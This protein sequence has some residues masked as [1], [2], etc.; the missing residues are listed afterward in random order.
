MSDLRQ[1][2]QTK[3]YHIKYS[4]CGKTTINPALYKLK[5]RTSFLFQ[6]R[7]HKQWLKLAVNSR[8][9]TLVP[10]SDVSRETSRQFQEPHHQ[11]YSPDIIDVSVNWELLIKTALN[12][13]LKVSQVKILL[14]KIPISHRDIARSW[15]LSAVEIRSRFSS[16]YVCEAVIKSFLDRFP[17]YFNF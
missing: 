8:H 11:S 14:S 3:K 12:I 5:L 9:S 4:N 16:F 13:F 6:R 17:Q 10:N 15:T 7:K 2:L 1:F